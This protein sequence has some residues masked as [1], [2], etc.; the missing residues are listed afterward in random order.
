MKYIK[1]KNNILD[2]KD[3]IRTRDEKKLLNYDG[4]WVDI[5]KQVDTIEELCDEFIYENKVNNKYFLCFYNKVINR[6]CNRCSYW[7]LSEE[8]KK[9][10]KGAIWTE[11]EHGEPIL[12]A[13]ARMNDKGEL[14]LL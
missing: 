13:V 14:E 2:I 6:W 3:T 7:P 12:K 5:L 9:T 11:G 8:E 10:I 4:E 1:T